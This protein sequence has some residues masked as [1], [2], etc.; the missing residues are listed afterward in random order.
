M[1]HISSINALL[2]LVI[3][4]GLAL[5]HFMTNCN[6]VLSTKVNKFC[7][8]FEIELVTIFI[9]LQFQ[10]LISASRFLRKALS[11]CSS[12]IDPPP[13][14]L[15]RTFLSPATTCKIEMQ[16]QQQ[17]DVVELCF[18]R[19]MQ[20]TAGLI[21]LLQSEKFCSSIFDYAEQFFICRSFTMQK[22]LQQYGR[23]VIYY[24]L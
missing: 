18:D 11:L 20:Q 17:H 21:R 4:I 6:C 8:F 19:N 10:L 14:L 23:L 2:I 1:R 9:P 3:S 12:R 15:L 16:M 24:A 5:K 13:S 22:T 7:Q